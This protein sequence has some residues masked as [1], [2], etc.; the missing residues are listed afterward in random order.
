MALFLLLLS[1]SAYSHIILDDVATTDKTPFSF[2][3]VC[4]KMVTHESPL[5]EATSGTQL[6]CMGKK[7][8]VREFCN[9]E[10]AHDPYY[11]RAYID[12]ERKQI[13]CHSGKKVLFKYLCVKLADKKLCSQDARKSCLL[14]R[15]KLAKRLDL[16]HSS[17]IKNEKGIKQL[18][19]FFESLPLSERRDG[20]P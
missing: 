14:I 10:M 18:S 6:D 12:K 13:I 9:K 4:R 11:I 1:L 3:T 19:C 15:E 20:T 7:I 5:I 2:Q 17:I 8:D 16:V